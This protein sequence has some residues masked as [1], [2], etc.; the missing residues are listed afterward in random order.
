MSL[1]VNGNEIISTLD[2]GAQVN[3]LPKSEFVKLVQKPKVNESNIQLTAYNKTRIPVLENCISKIP[4]V[5]PNIIIFVINAGTC[6]G[7]MYLGNT[8]IVCKLLHKE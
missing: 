6:N 3:S 2:T 8:M 7:K 1:S 4:T 5:M